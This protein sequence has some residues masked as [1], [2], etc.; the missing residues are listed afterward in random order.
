PLWPLDPPNLAGQALQAAAHSSGGTAVAYRYERNIFYGVLKPDGSVQTPGAVVEGS[1][2]QVGKPSLAV[3]GDEVSLVFADKPPAADARA[4]IR[5]ARGKFGEPLTNAVVID[6]PPGGPG[7][8][9]IAP[10]IA[11]LSGG[12]W[13][14][15]WTEGTAPY[16]LR[17]QTYDKKYRPIGDALRVSPGTGNFGQGSIGVVGDQAAV[18]FLFATGLGFEMWGTVLQCG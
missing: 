5:W 8:D 11:A 15:M 14:L 6:L 17:A 7:G 3:N 18:V 1:G 13:L 12:R 9:A 16:T 2:G 10:A 4:E